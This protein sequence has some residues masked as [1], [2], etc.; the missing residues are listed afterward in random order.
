MTVVPRVIRNDAAAPARARRPESSE[1]AAPT[2]VHPIVEPLET[3]VAHSIEALDRREWDSLFP[4]EIEDWHYLHALERARLGGCEPIY[5]GIRSRGQLVAAAPAFAGR[6]AL[7]E[8]WRT[9]GRGQWRRSPERAVVLGSP[10]AAIRRIGLAPR[11]SAGEQALL[12]DR[13]LRAARDEAARYGVD[14]LVVSGADAALGDAGRRDESL[15]LA[16]PRGVPTARLALPRW[17]LVD[18]LS[19]L[20]DRLR[21]QLLRVCAQASQY[22]RDWRVDVDRDLEPMLALC[23][24]AGLEEINDAFLERLLASARLRC[25]LVRSGGGA[26]VGLSVVLHD[27]GTLRE[28]LTVISRREK[29]AFVRSLIWLETLS[30]CLGRGIDAYESANELSLAAARPDELGYGS[31]NANSE[32]PAATVTYCLPPTE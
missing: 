9:R 17:S 8:L 28:K 23:R 19:C 11:S 14:R 20:E 22:E 1:H 12:V 13:L 18:Y 5:F 29:G 25:L 15:Q 7:A 21:G 32:L 30:F 10:F 24:E 27:A 4:R 3:V 6:R 16:R 31:A 26:L 2:L